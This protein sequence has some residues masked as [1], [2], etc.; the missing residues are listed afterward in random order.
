MLTGSGDAMRQFLRAGVSGNL[1]GGYL[2]AQWVDPEALVWAKH[3]ISAH[4]AAIWR[5][6]GLTPG[7][8]TELAGS[9]TSP[10]Q[11]IRD[12]WRAGIPFDEVADWIGAGLDARQAGAQREQGVT[13]ADAAQLRAR[14]RL[15]P[16]AP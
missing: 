8:A 11:V 4:D 16:P 3:G 5:E 2:Q 6:I 10:L 1:I 14:R 7:E 15:D 13:A 12:W 9:G